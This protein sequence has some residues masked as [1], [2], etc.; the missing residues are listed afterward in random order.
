MTS[1]YIILMIITRQ[2]D[3]IDEKKLGLCR[4]PNYWHCNYLY[5]VIVYTGMRPESATDSDV[6][7]I[8]GEEKVKTG[9]RIEMASWYLKHII[10]HNLQTREKEYFIC[11]KW[12][13]VEK[14]DGKLDRLIPVSG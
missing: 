6:C 7:I 4:L 12:F 10:V 9:P 13:A 1:I 2:L 8:I 5:E 3:K 11:E 14:Q